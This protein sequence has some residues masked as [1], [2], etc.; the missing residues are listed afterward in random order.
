AIS[1]INERIQS[2]SDEVK[3]LNNHI[4]EFKTDMD[5]LEKNAMR[6]AIT[7]TAALGDH[8]VDKKKRLLRL[9]NV[10]YFGRIDFRKNGDVNPLPVYVGV[11]NFYD[12][13]AKTNLVYDWRAPI[14]G[15][16]YDFELGE[17]FYETNNEKIKG[18][19]DSKR[20]FRIRKGEMEYMI[21]SD[22][23]RNQHGRNCQ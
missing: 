8:S 17:A 23:R 10:P 15:M 4:Q 21:D 16:F 13:D 20:Q 7:N 6:E 3:Y 19:I 5:H 1:F 14:S 11:H 12:E 2:Q 18:S 22:C 9:R